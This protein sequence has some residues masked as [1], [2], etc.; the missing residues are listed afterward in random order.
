MYCIGQQLD[1]RQT[2]EQYQITYQQIYCRVKKYQEQGE[3]GLLDRQGKRR[4][5]SE[6]NAEEKAITFSAARPHP[7]GWGLVL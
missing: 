7:I 6:Y 2:S 3:A 4:A 1:Y 5:V